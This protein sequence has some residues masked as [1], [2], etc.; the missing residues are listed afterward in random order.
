MFD[1]LAWHKML[2]NPPEGGFLVVGFLA[3]GSMV[4]DRENKW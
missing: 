3:G 1:G 4:I 2:E